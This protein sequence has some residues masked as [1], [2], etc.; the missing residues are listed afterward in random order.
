MWKFK[1]AIKIN[2]DK[3]IVKLRILCNIKT[4]VADPMKNGYL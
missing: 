4:P 1:T 2:K 3:Y